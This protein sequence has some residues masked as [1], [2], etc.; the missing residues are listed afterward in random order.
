MVVSRR[1]SPKRM[2]A[3]GMLVIAVGTSVLGI[4]TWW[5]LTLAVEFVN[6]LALPGISIGINTLFLQNTEVDFIGRVNG[7]LIPIYTGS[8]VLTM[9]LAGSLMKAFSLLVI[10]QAAA[11]LYM[12]GLGFILLLPSSRGRP[13]GGMG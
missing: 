9:S 12:V 5:W 1:M 2:L 3:L 6:G 13:L 7:L 8:I 10:F 11:L 4:S